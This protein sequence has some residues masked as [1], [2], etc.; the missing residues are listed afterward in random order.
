MKERLLKN[1]SCIVFMIII[2]N[3]TNSGSSHLFAITVDINSIHECEHV[4]TDMI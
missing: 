2:I 1:H 3:M 4:W